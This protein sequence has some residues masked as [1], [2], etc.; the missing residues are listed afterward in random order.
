M[1]FL[2]S[3]LLLLVLCGVAFGG[4]P[5][6]WPP[7]SYVMERQWQ[8]V[9]DYGAVG[10][11]ATDDRAAI[12]AALDA[13]AA[14][15]GICFIPAGIYSHDSTIRIDGVP[16]I[17]TG[18]LRS[19]DTTSSN[20]FHSIIITGDGAELRGITVATNWSGTRQTN[21]L[22]H[23]VLCSAATNFVI[24][25]ITVDSSAATGILVTACEGGQIVNNVIKRTLADGIHLTTVSSNIVVS[26]NRVSDVGDDGIAVVSYISGGA[27]TNNVTISDNIVV[28][29]STR[30]ITVVGGDEVV[31]IGNMIINSALAGI[32]IASEASANTY[33]A[34][35]I[36]ITGNNIDS[37]G[38]PSG[39]VM[40]SVRIYGRAGYPTE[41]I[42][43]MGNNINNSRHTGIHVAADSANTSNVSITNNVFRGMSIDSGSG[44]YVDGGVDITVN[45]NYISQF[46]TYG[47]VA[48]ASRGSGTFN[49]NNNIFRDVNMSAGGSVDCINVTSSTFDAIFVSGN[50][51]FPGS[52]TVER[53]VEANTITGKIY[54]FDNYCPTDDVLFTAGSANHYLPPSSKI[55]YSSAIPTSGTYSLGDVAV[56]S[57]PSSNDPKSWVCVV[58]GSPGTWEPVGGPK[59]YNSSVW[60]NY[61]GPDG[62]SGI[63]FYDNSSPMGGQM[64]FDD[65]ANAFIFNKSVRAGALFSDANVYVNYNGG[66]E[67]SYLYFYE[68]GSITGAQLAWLDDSGTFYVSHPL[69]IGGSSE[70]SLAATKHYVDAAGGGGTSD[71]IG[72]DT[73]GNGTV[74]A[75]IYPSFIKKGANITLTVDTDTLTIAGPAGSGTADSMGVDTDGNGTVD[76]YLYSTVAGAFHLKKGSNV[77]LTVAG[78]TVTIAAAAGSGFWA[79]RDSTTIV[80]V[81]DSTGDTTVF[82]QDTTGFR[83]LRVSGLITDT[84]TV[85][86]YMKVWAIY[87][88]EIGSYKIRMWD[89]VAFKRRPYYAGIPM[90]CDPDS[91]FITMEHVKKLISD[92]VAASGSGI[93]VVSNDTAFLVDGDGDTLAAFWDDDAGNVRW[94]VAT[95]DQT[96]KIKLD[97][98]D[99]GGDVLTD[100]SSATIDVVGGQLVIKSSSITGDLI[101]DQMITSSDLDTTGANFPFDGAYH[102]TTAVA[103]SAYV[104]I[105]TVAEEIEDSLNEY[106]LTSAISS[107]YETIVNVAKIGDDTTNFKTAYGWGDH[108]AQGYLNALNEVYAYF[109][110]TYFDTAADAGGDSITC[111][112]SDSTDLSK[113]DTDDLSQGSTNKY[114]QALPDSGEWSIA[115]DSSQVGYL[116]PADANVDTNH[117]RIAYDSSQH[118]FLRTSEESSD[119]DSLVGID[120]QAKTGNLQNNYVL[121]VDISGADTTLQWEVDAG[122]AGPDSAIIPL[123]VVGGKKNGL[124]DSIVLWPQGSYDSS[125]TIRAYLWR[126]S[127]YQ[128]GNHNRDTIMFVG[129]LDQAA[130]I[131]DSCVDLYLD[132]Y[133]WGS[134][135]QDT[136]VAQIYGYQIMVQDAVIKTVASDLGLNSNAIFKDTSL[137]IEEPGFTHGRSVFLFLDVKLSIYRVA[138][139]TYCYLVIK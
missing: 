4:A 112:Y 67:T 57:A 102:V 125:G 60:I 81:N 106:S 82:I 92:S 78:D 3:I 115:Y 91:V 119:A 110:R 17:G 35:N 132:Y 36:S 97:S 63:Y 46:Y 74:D 101:W 94:Q 130:N 96:L 43:F 23:A 5:P 44:V 37:A 131:G 93:W 120:I 59:F 121:K 62:N 24:E 73:D 22:A 76:G 105:Q 68:N 71:S 12:Q 116:N 128:S 29:G 80:Y 72:V 95:E 34:T 6:S 65:S 85:N 135:G 53:F 38:S 109:D 108:S 39:I 117:W 51:Y 10:D 21:I 14:A 47:L 113:F 84:L 100:L 77:T 124:E 69:K 123:M 104:T 98:L 11:S 16:L 126:D 129:L 87:A 26:G 99:I 52:Y 139:G 86:N 7:T 103:G 89:T 1:K 20:P 15:G 54:V 28:G 70:D 58:A 33:G 90:E 55:F 107:T 45:N 18:T 138:M 79:F 48:T 61:D 9:K 83:G 75:Y 66:D 137:V 111:I 118:D 127:C 42:L 13:A 133:M 8:N 41:N 136:A 19:T 31:I 32:Y 56:N 114:D 134:G 122:G 88:D 50:S 2:L 40:A 27:K 25:G 49:I 30:G 64:I